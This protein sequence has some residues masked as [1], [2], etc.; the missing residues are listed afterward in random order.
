MMSFF[1]S[2]PWIQIF[3]GEAGDA[4]GL[5]N[6]CIRLIV[7]PR[8]NCSLAESEATSVIIL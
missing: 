6:K 7:V 4:R 8:M 3:V 5:P 2:C 1:E